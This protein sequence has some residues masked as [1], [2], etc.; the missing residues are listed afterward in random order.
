MYRDILT[1]VYHLMILHS[2]GKYLTGI[3]EIFSSPNVKTVVFQSKLVNN[4][5]VSYK[6]Q[7]RIR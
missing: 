6:Y 5:K 1:Y 3:A 7:Y 2:H 4:Q